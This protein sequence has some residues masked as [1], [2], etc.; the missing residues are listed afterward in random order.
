MRTQVAPNARPVFASCPNGPV[1]AAAPD[2]WLETH[3]L[4]A[5]RPL[6]AWDAAAEAALCFQPE[7]S[8]SG[9]DSPQPRKSQSF[10]EL[11][12][13]SGHVLAAVAD[14][15]AVHSGAVKRSRQQ[16]HA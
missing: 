2:R 14:A 7:V 13:G 5:Q 12:Q 1:S 8:T 15:E 10:L 4:K 6:R 16:Q 11:Q 9:S 3:R